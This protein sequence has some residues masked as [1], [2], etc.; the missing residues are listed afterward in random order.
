MKKTPIF[1]AS[2]SFVTNVNRNNTLKQNITVNHFGELV[3]ETSDLTG[4]TSK[5]EMADWVENHLKVTVTPE[6]PNTVDVEIN[7]NDVSC[8]YVSGS[9][10]PSLS[11]VTANIDTTTDTLTLSIDINFTYSMMVYHATLQGVDVA[12][13]EVT[14]PF[15][16]F[17][18]LTD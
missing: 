5:A 2:N 3:L 14:I 6:L 11:S 17:G 7:G 4:I 15:N 16:V 13:P 12:V 18:V 1:S 9:V 10:S 8:E